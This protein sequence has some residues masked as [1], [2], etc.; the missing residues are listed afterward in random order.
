MKLMHMLTHLFVCLFNKY[1]LRINDV[2]VCTNVI[3]NNAKE[4]NLEKE[5]LL[6]KTKQMNTLVGKLLIS[7]FFFF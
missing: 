6:R 3:M 7:V 4:W 2:S 5:C 1:L